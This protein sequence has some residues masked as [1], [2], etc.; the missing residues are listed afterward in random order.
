MTKDKIVKILT[1]AAAPPT[2]VLRGVAI[3]CLWAW[4]LVP[5][6]AIP[7]TFYGGLGLSALVS[8]LTA[9]TVLSI[10]TYPGETVRP[11]W[12]NAVV[13]VLIPPAA[14]AFGWIVHVLP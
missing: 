10:F 2:F 4:F 7:V 9:H 13:S 12:Q 3:K 11:S 5:L 6:G 14:L 1:L 8:V